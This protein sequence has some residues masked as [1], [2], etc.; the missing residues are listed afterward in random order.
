M[1]E[2]VAER[3][4]KQKGI[5][6]KVSGTGRVVNQ[7]IKAGSFVDNNRIELIINLF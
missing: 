2:N 6:Y 1:S 4:L 7:S 3:V 5:N